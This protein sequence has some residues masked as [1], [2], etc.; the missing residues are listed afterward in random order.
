MKL[1]S[2]L[3]FSFYICPKIFFALLILMLTE[4]NF[5]Q[6]RQN[7]VSFG[8]IKIIITGFE[9]NEGDCWFAIDNS[10]E[11]YEREDS[12]W[13]GKILPI[14]NQQVIVVIDSL[15]YGEYAV[16]V[17]HD[18]NKN[19]ELDTDFLGIPD[20][21]YGYS[22]DASGWFGPPSWEKAKFIFDQPE[23]TIKI[24]VD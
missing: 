19:G 11:V 21:D 12:V 9:N 13:I 7:S 5:A 14:K 15:K 8:T 20:E 18:E 23:M 17:F 1:K 22:N 6:L 24:E 3:K 4:L 2:T 16:K 10:P